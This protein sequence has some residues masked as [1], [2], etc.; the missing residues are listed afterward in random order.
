METSTADR[1]R[2]VHGNQGTDCH[3]AHNRAEAR[4]S[5]RQQVM[6]SWK[7]LGQGNDVL[8]AI[9]K[10]VPKFGRERIGGKGKGRYRGKA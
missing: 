3:I 5:V 2:A 9:L 8:R 1:T 10:A 6:L 4:D 7:R